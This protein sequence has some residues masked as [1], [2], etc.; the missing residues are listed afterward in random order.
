MALVST[1]LLLSDGSQYRV[2]IDDDAP[3]EDIL[4]ALVE[5]LGLPVRRNPVEEYALV[6]V[7]ALKIKDGT[8]L[9]LKERFPVSEMT[10]KKRVVLLG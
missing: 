8:T 3:Y 1:N 10:A 2:Q 7:D 9:V 5:R 6:M 4:T